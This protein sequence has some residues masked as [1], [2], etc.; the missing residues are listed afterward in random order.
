MSNMIQSKDKQN[1][2]QI[3]GLEVG[4]MET[5]YCPGNHSQFNGKNTV[6]L[7]SGPIFAM[8]S[9]GATRAFT[10]PQTTH[11]DYRLYTSR[12]IVKDK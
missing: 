10:E 12:F 3:G 11:Q 4:V 8:F 2:Y 9:L 7:H 1:S 6:E 5:S